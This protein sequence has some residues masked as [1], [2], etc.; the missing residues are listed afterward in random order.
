MAAEEFGGAVQHQIGAQRQGVLV[1]GRREGVVGD[2]DGPD[3]VGRGGQTRDV[4]HLECRVGGRLQVDQ[5]AAA[6]DGGLDLLVVVGLAELDL[7]ADARQEVD[8]QLIGAAVGVLDR[9]DAIAGRQQGKEHVTDGG[10]AGGEARGSLG[11]FEDPDL[12]LEGVHGG[13][14]VAAVDVARL[15]PKSYVE[16]RIHV[17]VAVGGAVDHGNL[18]RAL[19]Q[20]LLLAGPDHLR[21]GRQVPARGPL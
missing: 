21:G 18:G 20:G 15:A 16:P 11:A 6:G 12:L 9:H 13:I 1:D 3:R 8:E 7:D 17:R 19:H 4:Q 10:H 5:P 2:H 14:R